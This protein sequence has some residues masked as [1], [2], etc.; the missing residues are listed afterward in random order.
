VAAL[1][2]VLLILWLVVTVMGFVFKS[3]LWL[4]I[5]GILLFIGTGAIELVRRTTTRR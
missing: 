3:L 1:I 4:A 2:I 5:I